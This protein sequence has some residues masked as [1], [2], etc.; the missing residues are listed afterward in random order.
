M[1]EREIIQNYFLLN[2]VP[3]VHR[4]VNILNIMHSNKT[5]RYVRYV[6]ESII[7]LTKLLISHV[8]CSESEKPIQWVSYFLS[9]FLTKREIYF[10][11]DGNVVC[12]FS[13]IAVL[14]PRKVCSRNFVCTRYHYKK[15]QCQTFIFL[16]CIFNMATCEHMMH[17]RN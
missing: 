8:F 2:F 6:S 3:F 11:R 1:E 10:F 9:T 12:V 17:E 5:H 14:K 13:S 7:S 4:K 15:P 16:K